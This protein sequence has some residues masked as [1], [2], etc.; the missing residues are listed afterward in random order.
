MRLLVLLAELLLFAVLIL[1]TSLAEQL[2]LYH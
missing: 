1:E 2:E